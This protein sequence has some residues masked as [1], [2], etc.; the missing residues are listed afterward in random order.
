MAGAAVLLN[1]GELIGPAVPQSDTAVAENFQRFDGLA[2]GVNPAGRQRTQYFN[3]GPRPGQA[4]DTPDVYTPGPLSTTVG[5]LGG[6]PLPVSPRIQD[7]ATGQ[8]T[9]VN[10]PSVQTRLG[11]GQRGPSELGV[12]QTVQLSEVTNNP[13]V[14]GDLTGILA[15][16]G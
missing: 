2:T 3:D 10:T 5:T 14:A 9:L 12:A 7:R 8:V 6:Q 13:P 1:A 4:L 11:V 15:G 16:L